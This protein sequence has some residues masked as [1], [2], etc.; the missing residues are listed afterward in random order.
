MFILQEQPDVFIDACAADHHA[1]LLFISAIGRDTSI[2]QFMARLHQPSSDGGVDDL[3]LCTQYGAQPMMKVSVGDPR[4]L[5]KVTGRMP[6]TGLLGN[7]VH[8][9]ILDPA[10]HAVD[11]AAQ[12]AWI[13]NLHGNTGTERATAWRLVK[14]L[15]PV[16]LL[17][18]WRNAVLDHITACGGFIR[19]QCLG[20]VHAVRIELN[21]D[22]SQWVSDGVGSGRLAVPADRALTAA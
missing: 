21:A 5:D 9:W 7:L 22:F 3:S 18:A 16:P 12:A 2:Q 10:L 8:A 15:S 6:H 14:D 1:Q 20:T 17:D 19:P 11:H 13:F 4:R